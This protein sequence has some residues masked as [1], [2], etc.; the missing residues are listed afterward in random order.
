[1]FIT[2][3]GMFKKGNIT[4][5]PTDTSFGFGVRA[6]DKSGLDAL[7]ALKN[8]PATKHTS[9]MVKDWQML[10]EYA[11]VP[12]EIDEAFFVDEP[13]TV[14][15]KPTAKLPQSE[16]WPVNSV[17]FRIATVP[18]VAAAIDYPVTATSANLSGEPN[19]YDPKQITAQ[20]GSKVVL[21]AGSQKLDSSVSPSEIW[22]YTDPAQPKRIR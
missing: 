19:I 13:R 1:L 21:F 6:D 5:Y 15:L 10:C 9:L 16:Y 18:E 12:S 7:Y 3:Y 22:D 8:R 20:W 4:A 2:N 17:G 14:I 11:Q